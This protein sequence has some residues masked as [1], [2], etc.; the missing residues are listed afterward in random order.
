MSLDA[1][2]VIRPALPADAKA[3]RDIVALAFDGDSEANLV[4]RLRSEGYARRELVAEFEGQIVGHVMFSAM[5]IDVEDR[6]LPA[7]SLAPLAVLPEFQRQG[8]GARIL[9]RLD[10]EGRG[11]ERCYRL[12]Q[13]ALAL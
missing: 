7:L 9:G 6:S 4:D 8:I 11:P 1:D 12:P 10:Q 13:R 5:H 3:I 2:V